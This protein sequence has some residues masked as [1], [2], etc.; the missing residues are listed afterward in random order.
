MSGLQMKYFVLKPAGNDPYARA[1][2]LA[3]VTYA[4]AVQR[5]NKELARELLTWSD[6]AGREAAK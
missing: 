3:M 2:R 6:N 5:E 4:L 1:S